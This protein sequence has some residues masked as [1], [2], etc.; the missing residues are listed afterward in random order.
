MVSS[1]FRSTR[2]SACA[3]SRRNESAITIDCEYSRHPEKILQPVLRLA[4]VRAGLGLFLIAQPTTQT[5]DGRGKRVSISSFPGIP[6]EGESRIE[7]PMCDVLGLA[8]EGE[9]RG[10]LPQLKLIQ[11]PIS[12]S[13][14]CQGKISMGP[15]FRRSE[16]R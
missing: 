5:M 6:R 8:G 2:Y 12:R 11:N 13:P 15:I 7:N 10:D 14:S 9:G 3:N 16:P 4:H 1:H